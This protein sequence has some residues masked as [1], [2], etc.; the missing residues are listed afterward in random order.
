MAFLDFHCKLNRSY[1]ALEERRRWYIINNYPKEE[2]SLVKVYTLSVVLLK[3]R[4]FLT[5][6]QR[7]IIISLFEGGSLCSEN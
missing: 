5:H 6:G 3:I 1:W 2:Q 4:G 7:T